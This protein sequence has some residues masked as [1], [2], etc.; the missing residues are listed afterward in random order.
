MG[1]YSALKSKVLSLFPRKRQNAAPIPPS[2]LMVDEIRRQQKKI[3]GRQGFSTVGAKPPEGKNPAHQTA[4]FEPDPLEDLYE[5]GRK[6]GAY[7]GHIRRLADKTIRERNDKAQAFEDVVANNATKRGP[8][9]WM[10]EDGPNP[11]STLGRKGVDRPDTIRKPPYIRP[12]VSEEPVADNRSWGRRVLDKVCGFFSWRK[13]PQSPYIT[14]PKSWNAKP[15]KPPKTGAPSA[16]ID[17]GSAEGFS[18]AYKA[19]LWHAQKVHDKV[20][21]DP[22]LS[23]L[24]SL[25]SSYGISNEK[26]VGDYPSL[27]GSIRNNNLENYAVVSKFIRKH[28]GSNDGL[29]PL[30]MY[31]R[32][33]DKRKL[34]AS[35]KRKDLQRNLEGHRQAIVSLM[36]EALNLQKLIVQSRKPRVQVGGTI[37]LPERT[38]NGSNPV[39]KSD[40]EKKLAKTEAALKDAHKAFDAAKEKLRTVSKE[41]DEISELNDLSWDGVKVNFTDRDRERLALARGF[42]KQAGVVP[43]P[44]PKPAVKDV[45]YDREIPYA[46]PKAQGPTYINGERVV[47]PLPDVGEKKSKQLTGGR[48]DAKPDK[49]PANPKPKQLRSG[50]FYR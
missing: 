39:L 36:D 18:D 35:K 47:L 41:V 21:S 48:N 28:T 30:V 11:P 15:Q 3:S 17:H 34:D 4:V 14:I 33:V 16:A 8:Y 25:Y 12:V 29:G 50:V 5:T 20:A 7:G 32:Y 44:G 9:D 10:Y 24:A 27:F 45:D 13:R 26:A 43:S 6:P 49:K 37:A 1:L 19:D 22:A 46:G 31:G 38:G 40:A 42:V 23:S 2:Q